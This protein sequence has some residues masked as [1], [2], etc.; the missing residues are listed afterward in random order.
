MLKYGKNIIFNPEKLE[1][2]NIDRQ[3]AARIPEGARVL[4]IGCATG[5]V[6]K[7]LIK[8]KHCEVIGVELGKDEAKEAVKV[9][10]NVIIGDI[11]DKKTILQIKKLGKFDVVYASALIEHLRDPWVALQTWGTFL[12]KDG[13]LIITTS[14]VVHWSTRLKLLKGDFSYQQYGILDNTHLRFFTT[15]TFPKLA[16][17]A[18]FSVSYFSIDPVGGRYPRVS[19]FLSRFFPNTF[20]YQMLIEAKPK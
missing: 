1:P 15:K 11:E 13:R 7:Y 5:F 8:K 10:Q 16:E 20:A 9:L 4:E 3:S 17:D 6:G 2:L 18:G 14:N 19:R 12:K